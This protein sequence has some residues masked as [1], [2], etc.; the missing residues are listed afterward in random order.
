M[1]Q[2]DVAVIGGGIVGLGIAWQ[3]Q[4]SGRK[5]LLIDPEPAG[6][7]TYAAAGML[8]PV[9]EFHYQ[10]QALQELM[11]AAW[12]LWP[13]FVGS[14]PG[15]VGYRRSGTVLL[16]A[17]PA[18]R[19][20][21]ADLVAAQ[22]LAGLPVQSLDSTALG[23]LEPMLSPQLRVSGYFAQA[24]HQ[25]DPRRLAAVL[26]AGLEVRRVGAT[27]VRPGIVDLDDGG[28]IRAAEVI[29]TNGLAARSLPGV[30]VDLP[31]RAVYGDILRLEVPEQL[32]PLLRHT[33]R[34][35]VRGNPV[36]LI[37]RPDG[38]VVIGATQRE[39]G[40]PGASAGGVYQLLRD[41]QTVLP[42]V[43]E[44]TLSE[45][46]AR[47]R[48]GTPDKAPLLGRVAEGL[49]IAT[50]FYRHGV[51]LTPIAAE[52]CCELLAGRADPRWAQFA[53]GRFAAA[54]SDR[55]QEIR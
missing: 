9:T 3:V 21:L 39:D 44:L 11:L 51:L 8:A 10:E 34:A 49:I 12:R 41:A 53:P 4:R 15:D 36:Y 37:P 40:R 22:S 33:L 18:D 43:A 46:T 25:V 54:P 42:A 29:V 52:I 24:D 35:V 47:A 50:G 5:V 32:Q 16:G 55:T 30:P 23:E 7:A 6:G 45:V 1:Q 17:D 28:Q 31:L 48:P 27:A 14:L 20:L 26:L 13:E 38:S 2:Y 19:A